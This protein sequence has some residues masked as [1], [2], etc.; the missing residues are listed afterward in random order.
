[1]LTLNLP[2]P[3]SINHYKSIFRKQIRLTVKG[4]KYL[5]DTAIIAQS[6]C[7]GPP[8]EDR[9]SVKIYAYMPDRRKRDIDNILKPLIDA[10]MQGKVFIDDSQIDDLHIIRGEVDKDKGIIVQISV[11]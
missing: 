7:K 9:L 2:Y 4:R 6:Q 5:N 11:I 10:M 8:L 3:P 1:M